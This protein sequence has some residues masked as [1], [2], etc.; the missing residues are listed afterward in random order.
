MVKKILTFNAICGNMDI[1][2]TEYK[3]C[4]VLEMTK[5]ERATIQN[6][7]N[8]ITEMRNIQDESLKALQEMNMKYGDGHRY[9]SW[10]LNLLGVLGSASAD[11]QIKAEAKH[12]FRRSE[13]AHAQEKLIIKFGAEL[14]NIGFWNGV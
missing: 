5:K 6:F 14:A 10:E 13:E 8:K 4:E 3:T 2:G 7:I 1:P 11:N 9:C 12:Q